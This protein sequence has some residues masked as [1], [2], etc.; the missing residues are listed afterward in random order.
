MKEAAVRVV[1][2]DRRNNIRHEW[3]GEYGGVMLKDND[4]LACLFAGEALKKNILASIAA[5]ANN[6]IGCISES[7]EERQLYGIILVKMLGKAM[8]EDDK[9]EPEIRING[10]KED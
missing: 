5:F 7:E 6:I 1:F 2:E 4:G 8:A 9:T 3:E 10:W